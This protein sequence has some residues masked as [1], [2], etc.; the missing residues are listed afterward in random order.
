MSQ[1]YCATTWLVKSNQGDPTVGVARTLVSTEKDQIPV[2]LLNTRPDPIQV[3]RGLKIA[4]MEPLAQQHV[5]ENVLAVEKK[6]PAPD[7][8][9][10]EL[11]QMVLD[12]G[13]TLTDKEQ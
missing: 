1:R 11:W 5:P 2:R 9:C 6:Q 13:E 7:R 10:K 12:V 3:S 8:K 4:M